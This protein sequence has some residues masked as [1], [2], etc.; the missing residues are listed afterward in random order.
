MSASQ[1]KNIAKYL[2]QYAELEINALSH[3]FPEVCFA[4]AVVVPAYKETAEFI[5]HVLKSS[6]SEENALFIVVINQPESDDDASTQAQLSAN[7]LML[8]TLCWQKDNLSLVSVSGGSLHLLLVDRFSQAIPDKQGVGLARKIGADLALALYQNNQVTSRFIH[9]TDADVKLPEN[10][11]SAK[12]TDT[13]SA[14][15]ACYNFFHKS[16]DEKINAANL[17]YETALRYYVAGL[18][19]ADSQYAYFTIGSTLLFDAHG[20]A[21][22]RGFPK[23][24]A[25]ED[26]YLLNKLAKLGKVEF[27]EQSKL[28]IKARLSDR[29]PFGTG[30][31]V[32][33]IIA[34]EQNG[35]SYCY[36]NPQVF[37]ELKHFLNHCEQLWQHRQQLAC[38]Y[39]TLSPQT[40][41]A[42]ESIGFSPFVEKHLK[43]NEQQFNK[44][45]VVWFDAFKTLKF[46]HALR[47]IAFANLPLSQAIEQA[48]FEL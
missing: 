4:H 2:A 44:Q 30:P 32:G 24:S 12:L 21:S 36:Y 11:F 8:G 16:D 3:N 27:I 41:Q 29:V 28:A 17:K 47:D 42:L 31:A 22:V 48:P 40:V 39:K 25:G 5:E 18:K 45:L 9:S 1:S 6:L 37:V 20:Y 23:R 13:S 43:H 35:E 7:L 15:A 14:I 19:F 10:Y 34:L 33:Q 26:F 46:I 38:W